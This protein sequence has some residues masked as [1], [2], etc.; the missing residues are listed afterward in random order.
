MN[1]LRF[2]GRKLGTRNCENCPSTK[3]INLLP[4]NSLLCTQN[5]VKMADEMGTVITINNFA[6]E[7]S[8]FDPVV[9]SNHL[10]GLVDMGR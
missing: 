4:L 7:M 3:Q 1:S 2:G 8:A 9:E 10:Y 6:T 5:R